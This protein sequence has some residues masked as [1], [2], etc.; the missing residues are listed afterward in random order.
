MKVNMKKQANLILRAVRKK[1]PT[2]LTGLG[3]IGMTVAAVE[4][5]KATIKAVELI[6]EEKEKLGKEELTT[7]ETVVAAWKPYIPA[8]A[9]W[10][11]SAGCILLA[12]RINLK[13]LATV[14]AAYSL[15]DKNRKE[16]K[17]KVKELFGSK[18]AE[19]VQDA[20]AEDS[21]K[22][23]PYDEK[24]VLNTGSGTTLCYDKIC[25]RYFIG[26]IEKIRKV[27]AECNKMLADDMF[28]SLN[29][30]Y[31]QLGL[32]SCSWGE[33]IGWN[34][35]DGIIDIQYSSMLN[36]LDM[37]ILVMDATI[38]LRKDYM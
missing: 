24:L 15:A 32:D 28:L 30:F 29:D 16:Y 1:S 22:L 12:H 9:T 21:I 14:T 8:I 3:I 20:I 31:Y 23:T 34:A 19:Q 18:K 36:E 11:V 37:P 38:R 35:D 17:E 10:T 2:I 4:T 27:E 5:G 13:R 33:Q 6:K 7:T 26:S 25:G